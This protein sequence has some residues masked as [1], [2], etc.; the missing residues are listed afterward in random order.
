MLVG[1]REEATVYGRGCPHKCAP[2][3]SSK[4][5][6]GSHAG[7]GVG[8]EGVSRASAGIGAP[9]ARARSLGGGGGSLGVPRKRLAHPEG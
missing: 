7:R 1:V 2:R 4:G 3:P 8:S 9:S 6:W 5:A